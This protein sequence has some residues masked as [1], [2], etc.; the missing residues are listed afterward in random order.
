MSCLN[1]CAH[2]PCVS[3][4]KSKTYLPRQPLQA[5]TENH[6]PFHFPVRRSWLTMY[7]NMMWYSLS[8]ILGYC[9]GSYLCRSKRHRIE[10]WLSVSHR[11]AQCLVQQCGTDPVMW[12]SV[13]GS[14]R[15]PWGSLDCSLTFSAGNACSGCLKSHSSLLPGSLPHPEQFVLTGIR[16]KSQKHQNL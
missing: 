6:F 13:W 7:G 14:K 11:A 4:I 16:Q 2:R 8:R 5:G 3:G 12:F 10:H 9:S 1:Q 15:L